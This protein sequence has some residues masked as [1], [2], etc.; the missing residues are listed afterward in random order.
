MPEFYYT[1]LAVDEHGDMVMGLPNSLTKGERKAFCLSY[2]ELFV[3]TH[4]MPLPEPP[5]E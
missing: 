5:S 4:W 1:C 2:G 3:A